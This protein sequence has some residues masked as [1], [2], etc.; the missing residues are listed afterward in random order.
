M[1]SVLMT[2]PSSVDNADVAASSTT[3]SVIGLSVSVR[4]SDCA[5]VGS[6][7][8][9]DSPGSSEDNSAALE[10]SGK[11]IEVGSSVPNVLLLLHLGSFA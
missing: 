3:G 7:S 4:E 6:I 5:T 10:D 11:T 1:A 2:E 9:V 8:N